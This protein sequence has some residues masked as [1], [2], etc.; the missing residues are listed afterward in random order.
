[1][2][3]VS[4]NELRSSF[5][6]EDSFR[7]ANPEFHQPEV[8]PIANVGSNVEEGQYNIPTSGQVSEIQGMPVTNAMSLENNQGKE[9]RDTREKSRQPM[10]N[11]IDGAFEV[12]DG[13][14]EPTLQ[15]S[16]DNPEDGVQDKTYINGDEYHLQKKHRIESK[17]KQ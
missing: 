1:M 13:G 7:Y 14:E 15:R 6:K 10:E 5:R 3:R 12:V 9:S 11:E 17:S 8:N 2:T 4:G 16:T